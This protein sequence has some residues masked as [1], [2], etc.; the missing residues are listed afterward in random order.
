MRKGEGGKKSDYK[1]II[2]KMHLLYQVLSTGRHGA[3]QD[4][5]ITLDVNNGSFYRIV[6]C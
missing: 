3:D 4:D 6:P 5:P 1:I 2:L